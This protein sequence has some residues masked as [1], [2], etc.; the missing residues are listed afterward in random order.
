MNETEWTDEQ[1]DLIQGPAIERFIREKESFYSAVRGGMS[2]AVIKS[3]YQKLLSIDAKDWE[4]LN[5][6]R[7]IY[8]RGNWLNQQQTIEM[9][10]LLAKMA[11]APDSV[12][13]QKYEETVKATKTGGIFVGVLTLFAILSLLHGALGGVFLVLLFILGI[14]L[15]ALFFCLWLSIWSGIMFSCNAFESVGKSKGF[16]LNAYLCK[17]NFEAEMGFSFR[18]ETLLNVLFPFFDTANYVKKNSAMLEDLK[19]RLE[20]AANER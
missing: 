10:D 20:E 3:H 11:V 12:S 14:P 4:D 13:E 16:C 6:M 7:A 18:K 9:I 17:K 2:R 19:K 5:T 1:L 8:N 15:A